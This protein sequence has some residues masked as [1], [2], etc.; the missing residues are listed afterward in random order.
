MSVNQIGIRQSNV[1]L[2]YTAGS[3]MPA[4]T[5][6]SYTGSISAFT[7]TAGAE[8]A[9]NLIH[10][11]GWAVCN[12]A[13]IAKASYADLTARLGTTWN[14][15]TDPL[16]GSA[17]TAVSNA[18]LNFRIPNL[19]GTFLRG[20]GDFTDNT[21]DTVLGGFQGSQNLSHTHTGDGIIESGTGT[22]FVNTASGS[23]SAERRQIATTTGTPTS[24]NYLVPTITATG[25]TESRPQN[26]G[27]YYLI[28][29]YDNLAPVDVFI[30]P[31]AA[32]I[33]GLVNN[34][35]G[36]TVGTPILGRTDG[37]AVASGYVGERVGT[38]YSGT[39]GGSSASTQSITSAGSGS[40]VKTGAVPLNK[41][42]YW[43]SIT[44]SGVSSSASN[45]YV[46]AGIGGVGQVTIAH[47]TGCSAGGTACLTISLPVDIT[48]DATELQCYA[49][50]TAGTVSGCQTEIFISRRS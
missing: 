15:C 1:F 48:V 28:K 11:D 14:G 37:Q 25:S 17:M 31:A 34:T 4:G 32:G 40:Y 27:V 7:T 8:G 2:P 19:Q 35:A 30:P 16:T 21:K 22:Y 33:Q 47:Y 9:V 50:F 20:V 23:G 5:A 29:L 18:T 49:K 42:Q 38:V 36:N 26:V 3:T 13:I 43:A 44:F 10:K 6:I 46:Y 12:G 45:L 39:S 41:G 24:Y